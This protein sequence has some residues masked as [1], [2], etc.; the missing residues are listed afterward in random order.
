MS[1]VSGFSRL[2]YIQ[3]FFQHYNRATAGT[4]SPKC[5][6]STSLTAFLGPLSDPDALVH[7]AQL[8]QVQPKSLMAL[9][10]AWS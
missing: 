4:H 9:S 10:S 1:N 2:K 8:S 7:R 5:C 6:N 3:H